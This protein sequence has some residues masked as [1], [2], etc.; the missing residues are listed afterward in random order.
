MEH[1]IHELLLASSLRDSLA[2]FLRI[3]SQEIP[4]PK[5]CSGCGTLQSYVFVQ[6]TLDGDGNR[7]WNI[8]LQFCLQCHPELT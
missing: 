8:P 2:E 5:Y 6:F 1:P 4:E 7:I 3:K